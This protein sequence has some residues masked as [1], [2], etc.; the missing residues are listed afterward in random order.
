MFVVVTGLLDSFMLRTKHSGGEANQQF[1]QS[2]WAFGRQSK[3]RILVYLSQHT[4]A[5]VAVN[6]WRI[7]YS[8]HS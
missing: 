4:Q 1:T 7:V 2:F 3:K 8:L 5:V 6:A